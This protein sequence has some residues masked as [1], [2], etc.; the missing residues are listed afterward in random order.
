MRLDPINPAP[1]V[2]KIVFWVLV[3]TAFSIWHKTSHIRA[4]T[5]LRC[6]FSHCFREG[7]S[8]VSAI[9][10]YIKVSAVPDAATPA[11]ATLLINDLGD[12]VQ[13]ESRGGCVFQ[14][15]HSNLQE[16]GHRKGCHGY[17]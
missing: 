15:K 5:N 13:L 1:P 8:A 14:N 9:F 3:V 10:R 6:L 16:N 17:F 11:H 4:L 12:F 7:S 2:T